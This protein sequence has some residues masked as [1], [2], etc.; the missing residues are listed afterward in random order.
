MLLSSTLALAASLA[1]G[2]LA[3]VGPGLALRYPPQIPGVS[4]FPIGYHFGIDLVR[5]AALR[6]AGLDPF[7]AIS[8]FAATLGAL[9]LVLALRAI[10]LRLG[11]PPA[12]VNLAPWTLL[13]TD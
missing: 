7:D 1:F 9:A 12:A 2:G 4:G 10:T 13:L 3:L 11:A 6:W 8:R 5:A